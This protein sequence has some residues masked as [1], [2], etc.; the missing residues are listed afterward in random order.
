MTPAAPSSAPAAAASWGGCRAPVTAATLSSP[1]AVKS[2][3]RYQ[4][5]YP[6]APPSHGTSARPNV[7]VGPSHAGGWARSAAWKA[8]SRAS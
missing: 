7:A 8:A 3:T 2:S 5:S 6:A 1:S 4:S